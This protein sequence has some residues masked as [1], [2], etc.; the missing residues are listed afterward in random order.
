MLYRGL[1]SLITGSSGPTDDHLLAT[2]GPSPGITSLP[3]VPAITDN[4]L[5]Y[6]HHNYNNHHNYNKNSSL[7]PEPP[8]RPEYEWPENMHVDL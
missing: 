7:L 4:K 3:P 5:T 2:Y 6:K 1:P 8:N